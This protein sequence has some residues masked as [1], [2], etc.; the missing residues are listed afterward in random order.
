MKTSREHGWDDARYQVFL[1]TKPGERGH[2][3]LPAAIPNTNRGVGSGFVRK[4][5]Y[6]SVAALQVAVDTDGLGIEFDPQAPEGGSGDA[7]A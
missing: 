4:Q 2:V 6:A 5:R 3:T 7:S 1:L